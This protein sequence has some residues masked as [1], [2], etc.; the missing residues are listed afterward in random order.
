MK[1]FDD[2]LVE[3]EWYWQGWYFSNLKNI[4]LDAIALTRLL[5]RPEDYYSVRYLPWQR[6][7]AMKEGLVYANGF[8]LDNH[9][10]R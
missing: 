7:D 1:Y 8:H 9:V 10:A 3:L 4:Q 2:L 5:W 6:M